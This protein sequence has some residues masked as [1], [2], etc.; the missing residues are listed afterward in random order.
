MSPNIVD[1][2]NI[3]LSILCYG[4]VYLFIFNALKVNYFNPIVKVF[5]AAYKPISKLSVFSN[6]LYTI[7]LIAVGLKFL[8]FQLLYSSQY[9]A[10]VLIIIAFIEIIKIALNIIF[11]SI[12]GSVILS[13]VS[14]NNDHPAPELINEIS[15]NVLN[16]IKK[17]IPSMGGLD[18]SPIFAF[19]LINVIISFLQDIIR[20]IV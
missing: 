9:E 12:I 14:P 11:F 19:I 18:F 3:I 20:S 7:G 8:S 17:F 1:L 16:P 6:Q 5:V 2:T 15:D 13:W 4:F 10:L